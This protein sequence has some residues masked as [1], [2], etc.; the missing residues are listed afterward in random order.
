[1]EQALAIIEKLLLQWGP[2]SL[3]WVVA[4]L[5]ARVLY[6]HTG[7]YV[8][9]LQASADGAEG[10]AAVIESLEATMSSAISANSGR[11]V[12]V[13]EELHHVRRMID[14]PTRLDP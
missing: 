12:Q 14:T 11:L 13:Q 4:A 9:M 1:M 5:L 2:L 10:M 7:K 3:G 6:V 8:S